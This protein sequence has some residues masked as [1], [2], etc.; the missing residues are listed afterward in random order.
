MLFRS[1][2]L[3]AL[4]DFAVEHPTLRV[5]VLPYFVGLAVAADAERVAA[6]P[7]LSAF[8]DE[9]DSEAGRARIE[10]EAIAAVR[11]AY[12]DAIRRAD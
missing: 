3:T 8:L 5:I 9:L 12:G 1:G 2:V 11:A 10:A 7:G 4:E 6:V